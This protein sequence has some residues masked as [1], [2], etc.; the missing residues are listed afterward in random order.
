MSSEAQFYDVFRASGIRKDAARA[1][2][3]RADAGPVVDASRGDAELDCAEGRLRQFFLTI[4]PENKARECARVVT[5][6]HL[7]RGKTANDLTRLAET[8]EREHRENEN[9]KWDRRFRRAH[10]AAVVVWSAALAAVIVFGLLIIQA[11]EKV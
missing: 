4:V 2:A 8:M 1:L 10:I 9:K 11:V 6:E 5:D 7:R 3:L